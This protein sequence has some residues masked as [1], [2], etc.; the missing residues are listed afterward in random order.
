MADER[1]LVEIVLD[2]GS[3]QKG[4][5]K[6]EKQAKD[7]AEKIKENFATRLS[8]EFE[9]VSNRAAGIFGGLSKGLTVS[10]AGAV[11]GVF[12]FKQALDTAVSGEKLIALEKQF[13]L[14]AER[15]NISSKALL[16]GLERSAAG[17]VDVS[18][19]L[20]ASNK[21]IANLGQS[22]ERLPELLDLSRKSAILLGKDTK[23]VFSELLTA[24]E[25]GNTKALR[26]AG[27]ILDAEKVYGDF[28][29]TIK[30]LPGELTQAQRQAALL[31]AAI[32][33]G[34]SAFKGLTEESTPLQNAMSR[35]SVAISSVSDSAQKAFSQKFGAS[36]S[37]AVDSVTRVFT[38]ISGT[39]PL[40]TKIAETKKR[41][42]EAKESVSRL[43]EKVNSLK[44]AGAIER[45]F[46]LGASPDAQIAQTSEFIKKQELALKSLEDQQLKTT[47]EKIKSNKK[48]SDSEG[49]LTEDQKMQINQ[50]ANNLAQFITAQQ[51]GEV[52]SKEKLLSLEFD[53]NTRRELSKNLL[54]E[55]LSLLEQQEKQK[56]ADINQ[57]FSDKAGF[58]EDERNAARLAAQKNFQ[59][60]KKALEE[61]SNT[62]YL[63]RLKKSSEASMMI[64]NALVSV[65]VASAAAIG[66]ALV[67]GGDAWEG[68]KNTILGIVGDLAISIGTVLIGIGLGIEAL[69]V[70]LMTLSPAAA[71]GAGLALVT[72]GA[73]LKALSGAAEPSSA[74]GGV[75]VGGGSD[76]TSPVGE[77]PVSSFEPVGPKTNI[78]VNIQG[79]VLDSQ[80][81]SLRIVDLLN[82]A[83]DQQGVT[84]T[85]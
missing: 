49:K 11:A 8:D 23:V 62:D 79:D 59:L 67:K 51:Q 19:L 21:A 82:S 56:I 37:S 74:G 3:I 15:E 33:R 45:L 57:Q 84:V 17:L 4:F 60:Q 44:D 10:I 20:L 41:I 63:E 1:I 39:T 66:K 29:K 16:A 24:I 65:T 36:I 83:F 78:A 18:D 68:F 42:D 71:L 28:A 32:Q 7:S 76:I 2:D 34:A 46:K 26:N 52:A 53:Y 54:T 75:A 31:D 77:S 47:E 70:S 27:I 48:S 58:S 12:A 85:G 50:R 40:E 72:I 55:K 80:E 13:E 73:G 22:A 25:N 9:A 64:Q 30:L 81:T 6:A 43:Q 5:I 35:L 61:S 69:K 38:D 14:L